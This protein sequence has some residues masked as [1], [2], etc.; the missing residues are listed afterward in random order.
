M[1]A[2]DKIE[3]WGNSHR[4]AALDYLRIV[5]G[6]FITYKGFNFLMNM[7]VLYGL[8]GNMDLMFASAAIAHYVLFFHA[9]GGPLIILGIYTRLIC[10][11]QVPILLGAI[12]LVNSP[13]GFL[14]MGNHMELEISIVILIAI[15]LFVVFGAGKLSIDE[16]RRNQ[17]KESEL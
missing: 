13:Q 11:L 5:V 16:I 3:I 14:S 8:T 1:T 2:L 10:V 6:V 15:I 4:F 17:E 9:F 12:F 7:D